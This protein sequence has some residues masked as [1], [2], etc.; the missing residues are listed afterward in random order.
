MIIWN[1]K[2][3][4]CDPHDLT[5]NERMAAVRADAQVKLDLLHCI[6]R[7]VVDVHHLSMEIDHLRSVLEKKS[8]VRNE[9]RLFHKLL[10]E[11]RAAYGIDGLFGIVK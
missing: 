6:R 2:R 11:Q 4:P 5:T 8:D 1:Q 3:V 10:V 9:E 7:G